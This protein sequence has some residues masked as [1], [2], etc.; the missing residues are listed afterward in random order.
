MA[1]NRPRSAEIRPGS[2]QLSRFA[3]NAPENVKVL[4]KTIDRSVTLQTLNLIGVEIQ[5]AFQL[6]FVVL[7]CRVLHHMGMGLL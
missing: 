6:M 7:T 2:S 1:M 4:I 5:F 3:D